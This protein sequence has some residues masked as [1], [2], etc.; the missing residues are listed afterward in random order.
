MLGNMPFIAPDYL[1]AGL[2]IMLHY[3][4]QLFG[5][6]LL[7]ERG[8][9]HQITEHDRELTPLGFPCSY[10]RLRRCGSAFRT[11]NLLWSLSPF[12]LAPLGWSR[13]P[14]RTEGCSTG[15]TEFR[16]C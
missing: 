15:R 6:K 8:G 16:L 13:L 11:R 4:P 5:V 7:R 14:S 9:T 2:L 3:F 10:L 1:G 12:A